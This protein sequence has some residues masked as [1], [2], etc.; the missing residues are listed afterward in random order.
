MNTASPPPGT[1]GL[2]LTRRQVLSAATA[3]AAGLAIAP[4]SALAKAPTAEKEY[5]MTPKAF[6]Y[7]EVQV[8]V[9]FDKAPWRELD[10]E[11]R[12]QPGLMNKTWLS[13]VGTGSLGGLYSFDSI[14]NAQA[15]VTGYFPREAQNIG[16][17]H[18]S[19]VFDAAVTE[20]AGRDMKSVHYGAKLTQEPGA[21]VYTEVQVNVPFE[22]APWRQRDPI[23]WRQKGLLCKTWLSG[24]HTHTIG[25]LDAFD[26]IEDAKTFAIHDFPKVAAK[27]NAAFYTRVFDAK[28]SKE[29]SIDMRSPYYV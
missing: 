13:G 11:L 24:L 7:T 10:P 3:T 22:K 26:T 25:G 4:V 23:L 18:T 28:A 15:F 29:A 12:A 6:V 16:A 1:P 9:P 2:R 21:F 14:A 17:T 27:L 19:R 8:S 5:A 20:A